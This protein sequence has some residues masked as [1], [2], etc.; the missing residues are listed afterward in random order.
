VGDGK[1][2]GITE[3]SRDGERSKGEKF[4]KIREKYRKIRN[5]ILK[6]YR[7]KIQGGF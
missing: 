1:S 6:S 5:T 7:V 2:K 4:S 3:K